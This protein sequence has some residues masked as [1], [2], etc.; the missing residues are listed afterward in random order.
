MFNFH[1]FRINQQ[2]N[3]QLAELLIKYSRVY[4]ISNSDIGKT[5]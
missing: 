3:E 5:N 1:Y 4:A 2:K